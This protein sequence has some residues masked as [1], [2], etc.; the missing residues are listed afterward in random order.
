[1]LYKKVL[2]FTLFFTHLHSS[3]C[4]QP[5]VAYDKFS[6]HF[7]YGC[8]C[9][10]D[11][12]NIEHP[13]KKSYKELNSSQRQELIIQYQKIDPYDD[14][15]KLCKEHDI[16]YIKQGKEA[17]SCNTTIYSKLRIVETKFRDT[18]ENNLS[19]TQCKNLA[20]DIGSV[21]HTIFSPA[22]D[23]N[24]VLDAGMLLMNGAITTINKIFQETVDVLDSTPRY[25]KTKQKCLLDA[26]N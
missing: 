16:C 8:F 9:G 12:P 26:I 2:I 11:Y 5:A 20:Y 21:F 7:R 17:K 10:R 22:D 25:P 19:N 1:M 14:I 24:G 3:P 13:S 15:D 23:E 6:T 18:S 4:S